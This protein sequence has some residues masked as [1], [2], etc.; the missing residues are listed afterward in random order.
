MEKPTLDRIKAVVSAKGYGDLWEVG[1]FYSEG[2]NSGNISL[3][4]LYYIV[5]YPEVTKVV[6]EVL[7]EINFDP[8]APLDLATNT[9][10]IHTMNERMARANIPPSVRDN[11]PS[12]DLD[13]LSGLLFIGIRSKEFGGLF[14]DLLV[15]TTRNG[16]IFEVFEA[17]T[18]LD[19]RRVLMD[20]ESDDPISMKP[21]FTKNLFGVLRDPSG[22][23]T[24]VQ[25]T[26]AAD[27]FKIN[28][29]HGQTS[30]SLVKRSNINFSIGTT[31]S[32][33]THNVLNGTYCAEL[34]H[35]LDLV[36]FLSALQTY[37]DRYSKVKNQIYGYHG[38][39]LMVIDDMSQFSYLL[40]EE[41]DF[42]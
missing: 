4:F 27:L 35:P 37:I 20:I 19:L 10:L 17:C 9:G 33:S 42:S 2:T 23:V 28:T 38:E 21:S 30:Y 36:R 41:T 11:L 34:K 22:K 26:E 12:I 7:A 5:N 8:N 39:Q 25:Q 29:E 31:G 14:D 6:K 13:S 32:Q 40:L 3:D 24:G 16:E 1:T 18:D 15:V